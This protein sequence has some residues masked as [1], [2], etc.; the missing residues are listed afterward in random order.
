[1]KKKINLSELRVKSFITEEVSEKVETV[2]GGRKVV[3]S[4]VRWC[5]GEPTT[6]TTT[7]PIELPSRGYLDCSA[8][9]GVCTDA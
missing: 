2:K 1:M 7:D 4:Y 3:K 9:L 6:D 5:T 8:I